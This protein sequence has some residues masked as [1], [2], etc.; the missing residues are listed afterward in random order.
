MIYPWVSVLTVALLD[1]F[2]LIDVLPIPEWH[3][4]GIIAIP[5]IFALLWFW[6]KN[7]PSE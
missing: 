6:A 4:I 1:T 3:I 2:K 7:N 5:V